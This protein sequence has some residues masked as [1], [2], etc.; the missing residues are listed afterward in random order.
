MS[1]YQIARELRREIKALNKKIDLHII[2]GLP[3]RE[4][5]RR[6]KLMVAQLNN[7]LPKKPLFGS[8]SLASIF[9]A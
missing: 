4:L 6:H 7:L 5:A 8:L 3:Y 2:H 1:K 9:M